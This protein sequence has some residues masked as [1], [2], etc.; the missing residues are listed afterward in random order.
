[1]SLN[2][3]L[4]LKNM[5]TAVTATIDDGAT[6]AQIL[7][8]YQGGPEV[9]R[10]PF[11]TLGMHATIDIE[12]PMRREEG[13][14]RRIQ[15]NPLRYNADVPVHVI[16]VDQTGV[17]ATKLLDKIRSSIQTTIELN[18]Q[19]TDYT[20]ILSQDRNANQRI[21]GFDPLWRDDYRILFRPLEG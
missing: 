15:D 19:Q 3:R 16:A 7:V 20:V 10:Y 18:A 9:L 14:R 1:M 17:T 4:L 5:L 8:R 11:E 13:E 12:R 2:V 21:G 6:P